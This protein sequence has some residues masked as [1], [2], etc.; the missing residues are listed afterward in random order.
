MTIGTMR[1]QSTKTK[2]ILRLKTN[3][4]L[5][6]WLRVDKLET[7]TMSTRVRTQAQSSMIT[8]LDKD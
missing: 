5:L 3:L 2:S 6:L 7:R 1:D 8:S 4:E